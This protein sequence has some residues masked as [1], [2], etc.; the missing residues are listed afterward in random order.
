MKGIGRMRKYI[1]VQD[2]EQDLQCVFY[3]ENGKYYIANKQPLS[4]FL[5]NIREVTYEKGLEIMEKD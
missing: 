3:E 1:E 2:L 5:Y 4:T